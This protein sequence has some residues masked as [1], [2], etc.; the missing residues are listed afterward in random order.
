[1][2]VEPD[3]LSDC[4]FGAGGYSV[5]RAGVFSSVYVC[6]CVSEPLPHYIFRCLTKTNKPAIFIVIVVV[7]VGY[8]ISDVEVECNV[9]RALNE[10][11][12]QD[13]RRR[14][15]RLCKLAQVTDRL[16]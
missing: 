16:P 1:M 13:R 10:E 5:D 8:S 11:R 6:V 12:G 2:V 7:V 14:S 3:R 15:V 9:I 4:S